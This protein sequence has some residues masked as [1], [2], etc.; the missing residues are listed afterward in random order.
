LLIII[1][2]I[3]FFQLTKFPNVEDYFLINVLYCV[4]QCT[5]LIAIRSV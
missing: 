2:I 5:I 4:K 3:M 1:T